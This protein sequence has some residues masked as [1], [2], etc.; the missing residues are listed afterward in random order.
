M[1][2]LVYGAGAIGG[3]LGAILS[4]AGE[5]VTLVAR[6]AMYEAMAARGVILES[7]KRAN[8][9][10]IKVR[11]VKPGEEKPPYDLI[12]VT[13]KSHQLPQ[14]AAH[15]KRLGGKDAVFVFPQNGIPWWQFDGIE[16]KYKGTPL[17]TLDPEGVLARTFAA[18][19]IIGGVA[20]KPT[21][22][23]APAHIKLADGAADSL[24]IGEIDN[25]I[26]DRLQAIA[27]I[28]SNA[29]WTGNA[30]ADIRKAK[31]TKLLSNAVWNTLGVVAQAT[32]KEAAGFPQTAALATAMIKEVVAL[33]QASGTTL[34]ID[35]AKM[36]SDTAQRVNLPTSTLQDL[37]AG[38]SLELDALINVLIEISA[39]TGTAA[40]NLSVV[41]ACANFVNQCVVAQG[42]AVKPVKVGA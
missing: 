12:Y 17:K 9:N 31:W 8:L 37:R 16:S 26:S 20:F 42:Y 33:A 15:V 25:R 40:P 23:L 22:L 24:A 35:V 7:P 1:K 36:V 21:D 13:L 27:K 28:S 34:Q 14:A 5:D 38:R 32:P 39:L 11:V 41:A 30:V 10:P 4:E 3:Y 29:G 2:I 19:E 6:G 18:R